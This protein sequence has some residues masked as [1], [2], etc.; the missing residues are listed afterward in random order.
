[1]YDLVMKKYLY[2]LLLLMALLPGAC[3]LKS[4][5][6]N[7]S[8]I[9]YDPTPHH[10]DMP[11]GFPKMEHPADNPGTVEGVALGRALFFDPI[12]SVD[13]SIACSFCHLPEFSFTDRHALSRG[14]KGTVVKRSSPSL[15]NVGLLRNGLFWDGRVH[16]LE[17]Q[18][19][20]PVEDPLEMQANW[21][22]IEKR[23]Q[24]HQAYPVLF[25]KA[26]GIEKR[27][28]L[29]RDL[30]VKAIAQFERTLVSSGQSKFDRVRFGL[31]TF[32]VDEAM[33]YDLFFDVSPEVKDADCGNCHNAP[34]FTDHTF[35]NN[36]IQA[37]ATLNDFKDNGLGDISKDP[38]DNGKF[39]VPTL[40][41]IAITSP[42]MHDGRFRTLK[43][44]VQHYNQGGQPSPTIHPLVR[45]LGL[46]EQ[47]QQQLISFLHTL[48]D[49]VFVA[50]FVPHL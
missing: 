28:E 32:T 39:K 14:V 21:G 47:E 43:E 40:Y 46:T 1:M 3:L 49:T 15:L 30:V 27:E 11:K 20:L 35:A 23:L 33:G 24:A 45:P 5:Q 19:L 41:N 12:L 7:L 18:A 16:S 2:L 36:G 48:T 13:S 34:L 42:Y 50:R 22:D 9:P 6:P 25:R 37:A 44:V 17:E 10:P 29:T 26:F 8:D 4:G 31:D 38:Y